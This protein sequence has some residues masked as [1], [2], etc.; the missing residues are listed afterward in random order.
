MDFRLS[1]E[2]PWD[3][4]Q[5]NVNLGMAEGVEVVKGMEENEERKVVVG[6]LVKDKKM[7]KKNCGKKEELEEAG[8][9][10]SRASRPGQ[11]LRS[12]VAHHHHSDLPPS[13]PWLP[14]HA[15]GDSTGKGCTKPGSS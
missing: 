10:T 8:T 3:G 9:T 12:S 5:A 7:G 2:R 15:G 11:E 1:G 4:L 6:D 14:C 13:Q